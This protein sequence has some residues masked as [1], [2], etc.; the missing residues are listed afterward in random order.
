MNQETLNRVFLGL[1]G[2]LGQPLESFKDA[3]QQLSEH[4]NIDLKTSSPVY[5][6][7]AI[8]GPAGQPDYLNAILEIATDLSPHQL[9]D[10]CHEIEIAGGRARKE[11]WA[12]RT[13]DIDLLFFGKVISDDDRL[14]L[15]HPRMHNRHF[16]L[17]PVVELEPELI[18]PRLKRTVSDLLKDL[19]EP[20]GICKILE[21]W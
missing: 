13:L 14:T 21:K 11:R 19:P 1:G 17:I 3:R 6:T 7:P 10:V 8:G 9:L 2:N 16:V 12:S 5:R 18:H 15:P 4:P 20:V